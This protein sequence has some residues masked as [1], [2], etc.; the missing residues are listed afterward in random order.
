MA[1]LIKIRR[2]LRESVWCSI[3]YTHAHTYTHIITII[4]LSK[5]ARMASLAV[6]TRYRSVAGPSYKILQPAARR[7]CIYIL[8]PI[9]IV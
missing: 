9:I 3:V 7:I 5:R 8:Y 1:A 6:W 2:V 4:R